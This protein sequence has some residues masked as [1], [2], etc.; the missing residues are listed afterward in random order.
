MK[1]H[2][3]YARYH[4]SPSLFAEPCGADCE[5]RTG[6]RGAALAR[7][8]RKSGHRSS[9]AN[10]ASAATATTNVVATRSWRSDII[11]GCQDRRLLEVEV[12]VAAMDG[13]R[14][15]I[16][17]PNDLH[18]RSIMSSQVWSGSHWTRRFRG[19][20]ISRRHQDAIASERWVCR[21]VLFQ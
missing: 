7:T 11:Y 13:F 6:P 19:D 12:N 4:L 2:Q 8:V 1:R 5:I 20:V 10:P 15:L 21:F 14:P 16:V 9:A 3:G 17:E 18:A